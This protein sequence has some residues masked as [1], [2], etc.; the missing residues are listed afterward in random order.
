MAAMNMSN[1]NAEA[2]LQLKVTPNPF[3]NYV[4]VQLSLTETKKVSI[5][6]YDIKGSLVKRVYEGE[7]NPG[8]HRISIDG[9][10]M[11][12]GIYFCEII[13]NE[14]RFSRKLVLQK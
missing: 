14:H 11:A 7:R 4:T 1:E 13:I 9:S 12:D 6:L 10:S 2:A 8:T 3:S 5:N